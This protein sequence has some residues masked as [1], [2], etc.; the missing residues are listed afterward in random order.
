MARAKSKPDRID[1]P[2]DR[3]CDLNDR[4]C[5]R[6]ILSSVMVSLRSLADEMEEEIRRV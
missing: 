3:E 2:F 4:D 6:C 5:Y 1:C